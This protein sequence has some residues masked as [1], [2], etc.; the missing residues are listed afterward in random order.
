MLRGS[1]FARSTWEPRKSASGCSLW[2]TATV[3]DASASRRH[4]YML[5]GHSGTTLTDA[6]IAFL[7]LPKRTPGEHVPSP[8]IPNPDFVEELMGFP[9]GWTRLDGSDS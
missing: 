5:T 4:G 9:V 6:V 2:P 7:G 1:L 3:S 8:A